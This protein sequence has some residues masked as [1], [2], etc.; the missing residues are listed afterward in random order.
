MLRVGVIGL[1]RLWRGRYGPALWA[2]ADRFQVRALCDQVRAHAEHEARR[3]RCRAAVGPTELLESPDVEAVLLLDDQWFRLWPLETAARLGKPAF[4][5][6]SLEAEGDRADDLVRLVRDRRLPVMTEMALRHAPAVGRVRELLDSGLGPAR[7][8]LC[9]AVTPAEAD[10]TPLL[11]VCT[12]LLGDGPA[13]VSAVGAEA[14]GFAAVHLD[15]AGGR[16]AHIHC[17]PG[18]RPHVRV[19]VVAEAGSVRADLPDRVRW[20]AP[21]GRHA[22]VVPAGRPVGEVLLERFHD[23]V[24]AGGRP[25]PDLDDAYRVLGWLRAAGQS[26]CEGRRV[27]L[28]A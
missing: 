22:H 16:A 1:G 8:V 14:A 20:T 18:D 12:A 21:D 3:W 2:L 24:S 23:A 25:E 7:L 10:V 27:E 15:F 19:E 9:D 13:S 6:G 17:R 11:D 28:P 5:C 26:R 4:C